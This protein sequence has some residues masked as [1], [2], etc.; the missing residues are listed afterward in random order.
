MNAS[1][2]S[3]TVVA[4]LDMGASAIRLVVAEVGPKRKKRVLEELSR[5]VSLGRD[6]FSGGSIRSS[7]VDAVAAS[8]DGFRRGR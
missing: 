1:S 8:L 7:T 3:P 6:T 5:A 2:P 4:V